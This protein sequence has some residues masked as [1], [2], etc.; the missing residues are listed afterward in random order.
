MN[1]E[2]INVKEDIESGINTV[3]I[4][5]PVRVKM[6]SYNDAPFEFTTS[7]DEVGQI[8]L[9]PNSKEIEFIEANTDSN[10]EYEIPVIEQET[11]RTVDESITTLETSIIIKAHM[12]ME[13]DNQNVSADID[14]I[15]QVVIYPLA[16]ENSF[17]TATYEDSL[18]LIT[19]ALIDVTEYCDGY[20][21]INPGDGWYVK[22]PR[23]TM[24]AKQ[25]DSLNAAKIFV[26]QTEIDRLKQLP[27]ELESNTAETTTSEQASPVKPEVEAEVVEESVTPETPVEFSFT[28][29][30]EAIKDIT[31]DF[32]EKEG[33]LKAD[34]LPESAMCRLIL[35]EH[36]D[37]VTVENRDGFY[38][39]S[40][41]SA[42]LNEELSEESRRDLINKFMQGEVPLF[43]DTG[44]PS[45]SYI[46]LN[47]LDSNGYEYYFDEESYSIIS[48]PK[49]EA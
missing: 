36:Y 30:Q 1:N 48:Y 15:G 29:V 16:K 6:Q 17:V 41:A 33:V 40:F 20:K 34:L 44:I 14:E 23:N 4:D 49:R 35:K 25:L 2:V 31:N 13:S 38:L 26:C 19:E 21:L 12:L 46:H 7:I 10:V 18:N 47:E 43:S 8:V 22:D 3:T 32:Q 28:Q 5:I 42:Q 37:V 27:E 9:T 11:I 39:I 24:I 45:E